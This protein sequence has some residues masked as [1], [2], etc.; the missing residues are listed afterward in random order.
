MQFLVFSQIL[1]VLASIIWNLAGIDMVEDGGFVPIPAPSWIFIII[2]L[3]LGLTILIFNNKR[4]RF[5]YKLSCIGAVVFSAFFLFKAFSTE[6]ELWTDDAWQWSGVI[7][8]VAGL[9][10]SLAGLLTNTRRQE[11]RPDPISPYFNEGGN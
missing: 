3:V 5:I 10:V 7:I 9:G 8:N 11:Y 6:P 1:W 2:L 4:L